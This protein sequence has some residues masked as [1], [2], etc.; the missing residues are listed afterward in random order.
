MMLEICGP[1]QKPLK[2]ASASRERLQ[3]PAVP[4]RE[5]GCRLSARLLM[6]PREWDARKRRFARG[7]ASAMLPFEPPFF[8]SLHLSWQGSHEFFAALLP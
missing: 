6:M 5:A 7:I 1:C 4:P 2:A 3:L 8:S